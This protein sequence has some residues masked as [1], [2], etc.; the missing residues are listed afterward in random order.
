VLARQRVT[1][2]DGNIDIKMARSSCSTMFLESNFCLFDVSTF[3]IDP[4]VCVPSQCV[5]SFG[6]L[7]FRLDAFHREDE[8]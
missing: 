8:L 2:E 5:N 6:A 7:N 1:A 3:H 4:Q